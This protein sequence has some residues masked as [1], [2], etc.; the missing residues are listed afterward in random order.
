MAS[1]S[2]ANKLAQPRSHAVR[3]S[4]CGLVAPLLLVGMTLGACGGEPPIKDK[5]VGRWQEI[6]TAKSY[7]MRISPAGPRSFKVEY[8]RSFLVPF[9]ARLEDDKLLIW[10]E[11]ADDVVWT[12]TYDPKTDQLKAVGKLGTFTFKRV[13]RQQ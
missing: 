8:R 9:D 7:I 13:D 2:L 1:A 3:T 4:L 10:G 12:V 5:A 6:G 11:N